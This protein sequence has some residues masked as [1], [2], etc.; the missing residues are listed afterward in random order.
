[1][2]RPALR[3]RE[4]GQG[5]MGSEACPDHLDLRESPDCRDFLVWWEPRETGDTRETLAKRAM[6][7]PEE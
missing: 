1:M 7:D 2:D 3:G 4:D 6:M 5:E